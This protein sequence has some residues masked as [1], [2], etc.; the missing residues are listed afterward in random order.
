MGAGSL[1][2]RRATQVRPPERTFSFARRGGMPRLAAGWVEV[3]LGGA[4]GPLWASS[5]DR[6]DPDLLVRPDG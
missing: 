5:L 6:R 4:R 1:R 3:R 2:L